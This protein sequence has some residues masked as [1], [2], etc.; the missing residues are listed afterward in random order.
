MNIQK[1][2]NN[3]IEFLKYRGYDSNIKL[4]NIDSFLTDGYYKIQSS[5]LTTGNNNQQEEINKIEVILFSEN[6]ISK[7]IS[8]FKKNVKR[9]VKENKY[10]IFIIAN[11]PNKDF[12]HK[13]EKI[14]IKKNIK[15]DVYPYIYFKM[16]YPAYFNAPKFRILS[17]EEKD[18]LL[19][20]LFLSSFNQLQPTYIEG[21]VYCAW[22]NTK[23]DDIIECQISSEKSLEETYYSICK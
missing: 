19:S 18:K 21:D 11:K 2:L 4:E 13:A 9:H 10:Y 8:S 23:K 12:I 15:I 3:I 22:L 14:Y 7:T 20:S 16:N 6:E 17:Q 5:Y 1:I